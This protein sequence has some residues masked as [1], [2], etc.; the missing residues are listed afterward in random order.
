MTLVILLNLVIAT[1]SATYN[2]MNEQAVNRW[3]LM[4]ARLVQTY[5]LIEERSPLAMLPAPLNL[6]PTM[7]HLGEPNSGVYENKN[8]ILQ[9]KKYR[10]L[11]LCGTVSDKLL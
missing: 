7:V 5:L 11:S 4:K 6:V 10:T 2:K 1:F 9:R 8:E 3:C